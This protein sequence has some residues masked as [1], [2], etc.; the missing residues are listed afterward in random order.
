MDSSSLTC[1]GSV[2][3]IDGGGEEG[4]F[5]CNAITVEGGGCQPAPA[6]PPAREC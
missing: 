4:L 5:S 6:F 1:V 2:P 3:D